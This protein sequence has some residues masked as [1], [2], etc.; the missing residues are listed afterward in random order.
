MPV[1]LRCMWAAS[2][3]LAVTFIWFS[4]RILLFRTH[5]TIFFGIRSFSVMLRTP[6]LIAMGP[7]RKQPQY[8]RLLR[9]KEWTMAKSTAFFFITAYGTNSWLWQY[10]KYPKCAVIVLPMESQPQYWQFTM[11]VK[12]GALT[13]HSFTVYFL[14]SMQSNNFGNVK[15]RVSCMCCFVYAFYALYALYAGIESEYLVL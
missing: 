5:F 8:V 7:G 2:E 12:A 4:T 15:L 11:K 6:I 3:P 13:T 9:R 1:K 14:C 10:G